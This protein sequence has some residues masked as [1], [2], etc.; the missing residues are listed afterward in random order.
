MKSETALFLDKA[1]QQLQRADTM[2]GVGLNE[3]AGRAAYLAG[4][5]AA[6]AL[7]FESTDKTRKKHSGVQ[8]EFARL[9]KDDP[10]IDVQL[11]AFLPRAYSLKAIADYETGPGSRVLPESAHDAVETARRF[12]ASVASF[13]SA[14]GHTPL[15]SKAPKP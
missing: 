4:L 13:L 8:R 11:R 2:L 6:Q 7:I 9:V 14:N 3:D 15:A 10:R 1:Q 12:V 5:H